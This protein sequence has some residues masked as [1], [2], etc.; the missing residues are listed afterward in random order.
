MKQL[1][2]SLLLITLLTGCKE[3]PVTTDSQLLGKWRLEYIDEKESIEYIKD[4]EYAIEKD[5][6][7]FKYVYTYRD[8][9]WG[10]FYDMEEVLK[11]ERIKA[12]H[13]L[14]TFGNFIEFKVYNI[15]IYSFWGNNK[16]CNYTIG[17]GYLCI[18]G[19]GYINKN[20]DY[21]VSGDSLIIQE[22]MPLLDIKMVYKR[23]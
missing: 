18:D 12:P 6:Y 1:I 21:K 23:M 20:F 2:L 19:G 13:R 22:S 3:E 10:S 9:E 8:N 16:T 17:N 15:M 7:I 4:G 14:Y 11:E 5:K